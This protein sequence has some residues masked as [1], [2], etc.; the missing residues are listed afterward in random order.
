MNDVSNAV[1]SLSYFVLSLWQSIEVNGPY[2]LDLEKRMHKVSYV[3]TAKRQHSLLLPQ[4][5]RK[6]S[7]DAAAP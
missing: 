1:L 6:K 5:T 2:N 3:N 7:E 4:V